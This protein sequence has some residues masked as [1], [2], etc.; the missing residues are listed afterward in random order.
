MGVRWDWDEGSRDRQRRL[1]V[2]CVVMLA[3]LAGY[4]VGLNDATE[5][6]TTTTTHVTASP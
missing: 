4:F 6:P 5:A 1:I 2:L 3:F